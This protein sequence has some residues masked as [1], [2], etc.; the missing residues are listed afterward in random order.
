MK[1]SK[2][3]A[4]LAVICVVTVSMLAACGGGATN[5]ATDNS[6]TAASSGSS[7]GA[8]STTTDNTKSYTIGIAIKT[9][10]NSYFREIAY[11]IIEGCNDLGMQYK[12]TTNENDNDLAGQI[13]NCE[14]MLNSGIDALIITPQ[15]TDG[16]AP[17]IQEYAAKNVPVIVVD[18]AANSDLVTGSMLM[19]EEQKGAAMAQLV[20]DKINGKGKIIFL[21]G[22]AGTSSSDNMAKGVKDEI[23]NNY[24][25]IQLVSQNADYAQEKGQSVMADLLQ[26]N[27]DAVAAMSL[28]DM[29]MLGAIVSIKDAGYTPGLDPGNFILGCMSIDPVTAG[30]I[31]NGEIYFSLYGAP[32]STGYISAGYALRAIRGE[33]IPKMSYI[34]YEAYYQSNI[35]SLIP[36]LDKV[37]DYSFN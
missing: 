4:I 1:N 24:P 15:N 27:P 16:I 34:P 35:D 18:T 17:L 23:A 2:A 25:N 14:D 3:I 22:V 8:A 37:R 32:Q 33:Y 9:L 29:M 28:N 31:Q 13:Q 5:T 6:S 19:M 36:D 11:G 30:L 21:E 10:S 20:A 7:G 26:A 12:L